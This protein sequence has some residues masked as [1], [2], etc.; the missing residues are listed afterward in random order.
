MIW[1]ETKATFEIE[2]RVALPMQM[3]DFPANIVIKHS[4]KN[5]YVMSHEKKSYKK[6]NPSR[7]K[8]KSR[9]KFLVHL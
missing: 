2:E 4:V 8:P 9:R 3:E 6:A 5:I 1:D 7:Q